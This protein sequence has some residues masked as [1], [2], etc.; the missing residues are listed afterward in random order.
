MGTEYHLSDTYSAHEQ[1][2]KISL[3]VERA[4]GYLVGKEMNHDQLCALI[5]EL[6][7]VASYIS[8]DPEETLKK[9]NVNYDSFIIGDA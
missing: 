8:S 4:D 2:C 1:S 6:V 5:A 9:F 7:R 3:C